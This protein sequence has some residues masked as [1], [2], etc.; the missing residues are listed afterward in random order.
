MN[1]L[2]IQPS[3]TAY[4]VLSY[5]TESLFSAFSKNSFGNAYLY[6]PKD[7]MSFIEISNEIDTILKK[8]N[9]THVF[10]F[11][12][13]CAEHM[14]F[15]KTDAKFIGWIVDYP[16]HHENRLNSNIKNNYVISGNK[17]H[18]NFVHRMTKS[19]YLDDLTLGVNTNEDFNNTEIKNRSFDVCIAGSWMGQPEKKWLTSDASVVKKIG[20]DSLDELIANDKQDVFSVLLKNFNRHNIDLIENKSL[21]GTLIRLLIQYLRK[22]ERIKIMK[23][24]ELSG[25]KILV[26]GEGWSD[27]ISGK[28]IFFHES[29]PFDKLNLIYL[30]SKTTVCFNSNNGGCERAIE[31]L[32]VGSTVFSFG[33]ESIEL[34]A[35][36]NQGFCIQ[37]KNLSSN[38]LAKRMNEWNEKIMNDDYLCHQPF[39]FIENNN[40]M[41][42]AQTL[43]NTF[44]TLDL[45]SQAIPLA[46]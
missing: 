12:S 21:M 11:N 30:N 32:S 9:I 27:Y 36:N 7:T 15:I 14:G 23:A 38:T 40:W 20:N 35:K 31:A 8:F 10:S 18:S 3:E 33:G 1:I 39:K 6:K 28:N 24:A 17:Q 42:I 46:S 45:E 16:V 13:I 43:I 26:V 2:L 25:L 22:Y 41:K 44:A 19:R 29:V 34:L 37:N 4:G 5:F